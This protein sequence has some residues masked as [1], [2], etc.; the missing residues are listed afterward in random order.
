MF[1]EGEIAVLENHGYLM[2]EIALQ[3]HAKDLGGEKWP[4]AVAP[5]EDW[6]NENKAE[7]A[8]TGSD[9]THMF[10]RPRIHP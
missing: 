10:F 1:S 6:L 9:K 7:K 2:A 4:K 3:R 8:L 5:H